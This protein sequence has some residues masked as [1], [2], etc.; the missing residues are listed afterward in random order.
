MDIK[1]S[2]LAKLAFEGAERLFGQNRWQSQL[3]KLVGV[4]PGHVHNM[5]KGARDMTD[6]MARTIADALLKRAEQH[7]ND[8]D[9]VEKIAQKIISKLEGE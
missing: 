3:A 7:R 4:T 6:E 8:A 1:Q 5:T 2:P 9:A